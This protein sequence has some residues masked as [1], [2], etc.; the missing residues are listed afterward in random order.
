[1][2]KSKA[3]DF[4]FGWHGGNEEPIKSLVQVLFEHV[5]LSISSLH[6]EFTIMVPSDHFVSMMLSGSSTLKL[7]LTDVN[8]W[9]VVLFNSK[10]IVERSHAAILEQRLK[11]LSH[12]LGYDRILLVKAWL[13]VLLL[14][15]LWCVLLRHTLGVGRVH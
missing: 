8:Y 7:G 9:V 15:L 3:Y 10:D 4:L 5:E 14:E 1:M 6:L 2:I 13:G 12:L 11:I